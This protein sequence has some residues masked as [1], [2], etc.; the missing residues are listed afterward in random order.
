MLHEALHAQFQDFC[1][2]GA[3]Q[4][5]TDGMDGRTFAKFAVGTPLNY[6]RSAIAA[7]FDCRAEGQRAA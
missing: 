6:V 7:N 5:G 2:F 1:S 3:G 4:R